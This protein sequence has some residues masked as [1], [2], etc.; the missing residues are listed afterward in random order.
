MAGECP[1]NMDVIEVKDAEGN[2]VTT[3]TTELGLLWNQVVVTLAQPISADGVYT[4]YFTE[5]KFDL[6]DD[7]TPRHSSAFTL[8]YYIGV[9]PTGINGIAA[10]KAAAVRVYNLQGVCV[11]RAA[12]A[13]AVKA[14]PA[15]VYVINGVKTVI[16]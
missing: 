4:I 6:G 2:V 14:L 1:D 13:A 8:T 11:L 7:F 10:D 12:D 16:R 9:D 5:G 3:A 15:G